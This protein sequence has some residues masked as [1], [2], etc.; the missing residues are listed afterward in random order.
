[1]KFPG[2]TVFLAA[3]LALLAILA[4]CAAKGT[5]SYVVLLRD[6]AGKVGSVAVRSAQGE[7][8]LTEEMKGAALDGKREPFLATQEQL[9]RDFGAALA[10]LP[11]APIILRPLYFRGGVKVLSPVLKQ[12]AKDIAARFLRLAESGRSVDISVVGHS[13]SIG[14]PEAKEKAGRERA[15]NVADALV[16]L[17]VPR[18]AIWVEAH[19]DRQ[20]VVPAKSGG[21]PENRRVVVTIR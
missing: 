12:Q 4:G 21:E 19:G 5:N 6:P 14:T 3:T 20:M 11:A 16:E 18:E 10:A 15:Q 13:D 7:Q 9:K 2:K 17:G 8:V 1:M